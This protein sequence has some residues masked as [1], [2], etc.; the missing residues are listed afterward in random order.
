[1]FVS[2]FKDAKE[3]IGFGDACWTKVLI[4]WASYREKGLTQH[5][6]WWPDLYR[7]ACERW[8]VKPDEEV[9]AFNTT[10]EKTRADLKDLVVSG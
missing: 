5:R 8:G 10:Y 1:L 3:A 9:L 4:N 2:Q 7:T 6:N